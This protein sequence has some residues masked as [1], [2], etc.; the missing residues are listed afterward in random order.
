MAESEKSVEVIKPGV[1]YFAPCGL[2][3]GVGG[4]ARLGNMIDT[5]GHLET[6]VQ[7]ISYLPGE[8]FEVKHK[9]INNRLNT[10]TVSVK[11]S[12]PKII[13]L[14]ALRLIFI[15]GLKYIGKSN[16]IF[17]HAPTIV[18]G[19]PAFI[20]SKIFNKPFVIDHMDIKDPDTPGFIYSRVLKSANT[21]FTISRYLEEEVKEIGGRNAVYLPIFLDTNVFRM[22]V[23]ARAEIREKL[24]IDDKEIVIG[25]AGSFSRIEGLPFLLRAFKN[26]SGKYESVK[27]LAVGGR[28]VPDSD[29]VEKLIDKL[30][31][32]E[33]VIVIPPQPHELMP[34]YLSAFDI[35]C[36][37]KI[38]CEENRAANPIKI[39]EYMSVGLPM[40]VSAVG[41][42]SEII[43]NGHDGFLV[44]PEDED[45]LER[46][47]GYVI[48]NLDSAEAV[49]KRAREKIIKNYT[50]RVMQK[51]IGETL[52]QLTFGGRD[53]A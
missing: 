27:L 1:L 46:T 30:N 42:P 9:Q 12:S 23:P 44:K 4:G 45:D 28:N 41:E 40:V 51:R 53:N 31:L 16:I 38:D 8:K 36:S 15:Y 20:L 37:P 19:F 49:G 2:R 25:Y 32:K 14:F 5:L 39:Y 52:K 6:N 18:S 33:R 13:K 11:R 22:D 50:Q 21:V 47:L 17:A 48:Q 26:L 43:E 34:K 3:E 35:A 24:G 29:D 7:L 10:T